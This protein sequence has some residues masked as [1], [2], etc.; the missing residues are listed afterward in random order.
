MKVKKM[1]NREFVCVQFLIVFSFSSLSYRLTFDRN[2]FKDS[3]DTQPW[4]L[5][6]LDRVED[7]G[8]VLVRYLGIDQGR[9]LSSVAVLCSFFCNVHY[10]LFALV[11]SLALWAHLLSAEWM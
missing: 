2:C 6:R 9:M 3:L 1:T 7:F 5:S 4:H 10:V 11:L 8:V